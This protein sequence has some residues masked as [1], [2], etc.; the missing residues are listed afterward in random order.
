[1]H[2]RRRVTPEFPGLYT[3]LNH[4]PD[5]CKPPIPYEL[6]SHLMAVAFDPPK[7]LLKCPGD[8]YIQAKGQVRKDLQNLSPLRACLQHP[9]AEGR[10]GT[11]SVQ[12]RILEHIRVSDLK[13]SQVMKVEASIVGDAPTPDA[14]HRYSKGAPIT[15]SQP[16]MIVAAKLY[17]PLYVDLDDCWPDPFHNCDA[18]L[19]LETEAYRDY[20]RPLYG[21]CVPHFYGSFTIDVPVPDDPQFWLSSFETD[22]LQKPKPHTRPV[23]AILYE[24]IPGISLDPA[25]EDRIFNQSQRKEIMRALITA[26]SKTRQLDVLIERDFM[27]RNVVVTSAEEG[28]PADIRLIDFGAAQCGMRRKLEAHAPTTE[29]EPTSQMLERWRDPEDSKWEAPSDL[30][31]PFADLVDWEWDEWLRHEYSLPSHQ[32]RT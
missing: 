2:H 18:A 4:Y 30:R 15:L 16:R 11:L 19:A 20:L 25:M 10:L 12:L 6:G 17:D 21:T 31:Y 13:N 9:P 22:Q 14:S 26:E 27:P 7:G 23:R 24:Y 5:E 32:M 1:M 28:Q 8:W 29:P 3:Y